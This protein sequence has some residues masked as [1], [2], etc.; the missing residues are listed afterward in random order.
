MFD[1][2]IHVI[3]WWK[4]SEIEYERISLI[5]QIALVERYW[6]ADVSGFVERY[7]CPALQKRPAA[8]ICKNFFIDNQVYIFWSFINFRNK[9][10]FLCKR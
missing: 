9:I 7:W 10:S 5:F 4:F 3:T 6:Q 8:T 1:F 2:I